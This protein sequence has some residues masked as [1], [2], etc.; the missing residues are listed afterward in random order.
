M[1]GCAARAALRGRLAPEPL[2][3]FMADLPPDRGP[4]DLA[5]PAAVTHWI[6]D[7]LHPRWG[8]LMAL[9]ILWVVLGIL[10]FL[11]P[12]AASVALT[13]LLGALFAVGG[14]VQT[15]QAFATRG[16]RGQALHVA[17]GLLSL[18]LG[19]VLLIFPLSGV[20]SLTLLLSAF[21]IVIGAMRA[22][23]AI[24]HRGTRYWGWMLF[25][26]LLSIVVGGLIWFQWPTSA[27][28]AIG[29][30][31]GVEL[32]FFGWAMINLALAARHA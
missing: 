31:V 1:L 17:S 11:A 8:W 19:L 6:A 18:A 16:W 25:S 13:L 14:G 26:S 5:D 30:L 4:G 24:Q 7:E 3:A 27:L 10:A 22:A 28:W 29:V 32:I 20:L 9:G 23:F 2:G 21:F 12:F 15:I